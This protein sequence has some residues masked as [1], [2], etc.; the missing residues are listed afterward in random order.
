MRKK[1]TGMDAALRS[2]AMAA[3]GVCVLAAADAP[4]ALKPSPAISKDVAAFPRIA[5]PADAATQR[6]N[7]A[8]DRLDKNVKS[9]ASQCQGEGWTREITVAMRG[10]RYLSLAAEDSWDCGGAHPDAARL[11]VVYDLGTGSPVNWARLLPASMI[12]SASLDTAGDGTRIGVIQSHA[13]QNYYV[14]ARTSDPKDPLDP[15]C[16]DVVEDPA[17]RFNLW[18]DAEGGGIQIEPEGLPRAAAACGDNVLIPVA[19]LRKMG[20][21]PALLDAIESA[22]AHGWFGARP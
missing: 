8:L 6:I 7:L 9:A 1:V 13:L 16:K 10:P 17:L 12:Q 19:A 18:P 11:V 21:Q 3:L 22:H 4:V 20:V 14:K 2:M 15:E 5:A